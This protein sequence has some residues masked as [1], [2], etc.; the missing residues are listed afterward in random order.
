[1]TIDGYSHCGI[2]KYL[3]VDAVL[4]VMEQAGVERAVLVQHLGEFDNGYIETCVAEHP[5]RFAAVGLVDHR[6]ADWQDTLD[7][8]AESRR[9]RGIRIPQEAL[10]ENP[11][12]CAGVMARSLVALFDLPDGV[13]R[14][15]SRL[16]ALAREHPDVPVVISHLGYPEVGDG[17]IVRGGEIAEL[18]AEP[19]IAVLLSGQSQFCAYPYVPLSD[20]R[21]AVIGAFGP[22][23]VMWG[24]NYPYLTDDDDYA[25][26]LALTASLASL[27]EP[28]AAA[29]VLGGTAQRVFFAP[30]PAGAT[31]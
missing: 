15:T 28:A 17:R 2:S 31:P 5:G 23:R 19:S 7:R 18:A 13:G 3:P 26:D 21:D 1:V 25:R 4:R 20:L 8:I 6:G 11:A 16:R 30:H 24:S 10:T 14:V 9:L 29:S 12:F 27:S 22:E